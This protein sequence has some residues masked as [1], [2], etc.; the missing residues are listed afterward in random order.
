MLTKFT[1]KKKTAKSQIKKR[2][3]NN[4]LFIA[5]SLK[6]NFEE[7]FHWVNTIIDVKWIVYIYISL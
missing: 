7:T 2:Q 3:Y 1:K 5:I 4:L 6:K